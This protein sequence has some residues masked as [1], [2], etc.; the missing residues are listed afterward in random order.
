[1]SVGP[2]IPPARAHSRARRVSDDYGFGEKL[3]GRGVRLLG[4]DG[5]FN[6][7][8]H[9]R[10]S[11]FVYQWLIEMPWWQF[12]GYVLGYYVGINVLLACLFM[13]AG[14]GGISNVRHDSWL[15]EF[16]SC[17][18]FSVQTFTTVGYGSMS[19]TELPHELLA[20]FGALVGLMSVALATGLFFARFSRPR[21]MVV[22]SD[23][24]LIAP[25]AG[26]AAFEFRLASQA[27]SK[28]LTVRAEVVYSW[29]EHREGQRRRNFET[30]ALE[31]DH[32]AMF[33]LNWTVVHPIDA[34]SPFAG[35]TREQVAEQDGEFIVQISGYDETYARQVYAHTSYRAE[36]L[37]WGARYQP[38][39][40]PGENGE[41][42]LHLDRIDLCERAELPG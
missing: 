35:R 14:P 31:R 16:T 28:L 2:T 36:C 20:T 40:F 33:P 18:F 25:Y 13:L 37:V 23:K 21:Q 29:V 19:P 42:N 6:V 27:P 38:M 12:F 30:L 34:A 5:S 17:F 32:I 9:G 10:R 7:V 22:S 39:Y 4:K 26:G 8:R 3:A 15:S 1:M 24:A 11:R 41:T